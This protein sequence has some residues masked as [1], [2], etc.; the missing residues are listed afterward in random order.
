MIFFEG[1]KVYMNGKYPA[2]WLN[3][4]SCHIHRLVWEKNNGKIPKCYVIHHKDE[5]KMNWNLD[6]LELLNRSK[7]IRK[8]SDIIH[9]KGVK[10]EAR[11]NNTVCVYGSIKEAAE[12]CG[13]YTSL[14]QRVLKGTQKQ[15]NGWQFRKV[16]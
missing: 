15:S 14:I 10:I 13:T 8:H 3:G 16:G 12:Q 2:I 5:N 1:H 4:G 9:R 6:N 7:H 11:K